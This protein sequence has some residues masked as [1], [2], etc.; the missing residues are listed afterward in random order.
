MTKQQRLI[1]PMILLAFRPIYK[2]FDCPQ[3]RHLLA[4]P[5]GQ[6]QHNKGERFGGTGCTAPGCSCTIT[7]ELGERTE[8]SGEEVERAW[9]VYVST[10]GIVPPPQSLRWL[11]PLI[12][13]ANPE[14]GAQAYHRMLLGG[15]RRWTIYC[16]DCWTSGYKEM[17]SDQEVSRAFEHHKRS[18]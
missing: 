6:T 10:Y 4:N 12:C 3:C 16:D 7:W 8:Y 13:P 2:T 9:H 11:E 5:K 14:H 1:E 17:P 15:I 18:I